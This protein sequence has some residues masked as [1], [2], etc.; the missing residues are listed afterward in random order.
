MDLE[1]YEKEQSAGGPALLSILPG[2]VGFAGCAG[3]AG[4]AEFTG[5][6]TEALFSYILVSA[7]Q[8]WPGISCLAELILLLIS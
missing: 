3:Y 5:F 8:F 7:E 2:Y 4:C 6:G 1:G